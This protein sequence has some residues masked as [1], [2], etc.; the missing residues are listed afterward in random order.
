MAV[1]LELP[2]DLQK[3]AEKAGLLAPD[4][5]EAMLRENLRRCH[6]RE[7]QQDARKMATDGIPPMTLEEIQEEVDAV[8]AERRAKMG[9]AA[10][11]LPR[12]LR[13]L[14][15]IDEEIEEDGLPQVNE[16]ARSEARRVLLALSSQPLAPNVYPTEDGEISLSFK[17]PD[18][19]AA[20]HVLLDN[21]GEAAW[22]SVIPGMD[23]YG[24]FKN[25]VELPIDFLM[26]RLRALAQAPIGT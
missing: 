22:F 20:L 21:Q 23:A 17:A 1:T 16:S 11:W 15:E 13:E 26:T 9:A 8:R 6:L 3:E 14:D 12:A 10:G 2:E 4:A 19:P 25:P 24:R 5:V 18:A 7:M